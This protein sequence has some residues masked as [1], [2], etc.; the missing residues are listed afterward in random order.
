[1]R[2]Y[3]FIQLL[4]TYFFGERVQGEKLPE[5]TFKTVYPPK[6]LS[7]NEWYNEFRIGVL[8]PRKPVFFG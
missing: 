4:L 2:L 1:M 3:L 7:E 6:P 8:A 5:P